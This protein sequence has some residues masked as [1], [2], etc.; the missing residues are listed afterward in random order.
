MH[1][2]TKCRVQKAESLIKKFSSG[3]LAQ[4]DLIPALNG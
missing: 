2:L 4:R 1:I 3:S